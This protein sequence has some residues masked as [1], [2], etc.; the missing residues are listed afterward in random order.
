MG[1]DNEIRQL[2]HREAEDFLKRA[3]E[4]TREVHEV[5]D[6]E[7]EFSKTRKNRSLMVPFVTI[8]TLAVLGLVAW[9][10]TNWIQ[11]ATNAAP[12]DVAAFEDL[13]LRD[14]LDSA[15]R[16]ENDMAKA[17][18]E[19]QQLNFDQKA[20]LDA[21]ARDYSTSVEAIKASSLNSADEER[22]LE[23]AAATRDAKRQQTL[24]SYGPRIAAKKA[25]IAEIQA[26]IDKYDQR[27]M[28]QAKDQQAVLDNATKKYDLERQQLVADYEKRLSDLQARR[29]SDIAALTKQRE[30]ISAALTSRFNPTFSDA[31]MRSLLEAWKPPA[32]Y[33]PYASLPD[34]L[35]KAGVLAAADAAK[36]DSS[37]ANFSY[38]S[39]ELRAVPWINSVPQA[40]SR[41]QGEGL[42]SAAVYRSAL[43]AA[44]AAL[45]NRDQ[46]V[47]ALTA[48]A[49]TA[50]TARDQLAW[51]ISDFA[52]RQRE[53]GFIVDPRDPAA[54]V[55]AMNPSV[56]VADGSLAYVLRGEKSVGTMRISVKDGRI[57]GSIVTSVEGEQPMPFDSLLLSSTPSP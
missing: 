56:P 36:L 28:Q 50:E 40:L 51:A 14:L 32:A 35:V 19:L 54:V 57:L 25:E 23:Q 39:G 21:V 47:A 7:A 41:L 48:R 37:L 24:G 8:A 53:S 10:I 9:G 5:Y 20:S 2:I 30:D 31:K 27:L 33:G 22:R 4:A 11:A 45:Q 46:A 13:N 12:V 42:G 29:Q 55:I 3:R 52:D 15:K 18:S 44:A 16:N 34:Y 43:V 26:K 17:Q 38:I 49:T 1:D 6:L